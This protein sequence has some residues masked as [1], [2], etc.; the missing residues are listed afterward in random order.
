MISAMMVPTLGALPDLLALLSSL[1]PKAA[2]CS[3]VVGSMG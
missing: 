2:N 1:L 3:A